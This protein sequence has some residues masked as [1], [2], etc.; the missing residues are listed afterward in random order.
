MAAI[1]M[2]SAAF[3]P[4]R[5]LA[6]TPL[7]YA[8]KSHPYPTTNKKLTEESLNKKGGTSMGSYAMCCAVHEKQD[9]ELGIIR[10]RSMLESV[11]KYSRE[12]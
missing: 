8:Q 9:A 1:D 4:L 6:P 5:Y 3:S 11:S 12:G 10:V 7:P 2:H